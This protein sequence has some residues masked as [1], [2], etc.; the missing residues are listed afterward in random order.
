M[1]DPVEIPHYHADW[2]DMTDTPEKEFIEFLQ[3][4]VDSAAQ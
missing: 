4:S 3:N 1:A 2:V